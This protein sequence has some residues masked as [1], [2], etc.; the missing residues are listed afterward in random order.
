[1]LADTSSSNFD[2][3]FFTAA[4]TLPV[5]I[6]EFGPVQAM[7]TADSEELMRRANAAG[8]PWL[9]WAFHQR[10]SYPEGTADM[11]EDD[12]SGGCGVNM[13]LRLSDWGRRVKQ[14]L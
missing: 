13:P 10:C 9:A 1:L 3:Y 6:G 14:F 5:V 4:R 12:S 8:I 11:L 7:T 2:R